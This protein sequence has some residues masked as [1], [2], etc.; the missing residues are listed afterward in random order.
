MHGVSEVIVIVL[1]LM[2]TAAMAS[3]AF[4]FFSETA[5]SVS[6]TTS[7]VADSAAQVLSSSMTIEGM[8]ANT[9]YVRNNGKSDLKDFSVFVNDAPAGNFTNDHPTLRRARLQ[10]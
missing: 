10:S 8:A 9:V 6:T 1:I 4:M 2:I 7:S 5:S 3:L